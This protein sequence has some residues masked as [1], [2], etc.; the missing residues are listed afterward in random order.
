[1]ARKRYLGKFEGC[2]DDRLGEALYNTYPDETC[3][4]VCE[5]G[6]W[7]GLI[8]RSRPGKPSY[9]VTE[10]SQGFVDYAAFA[11]ED[12]AE[13]AFAGLAAELAPED[14]EEE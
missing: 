14:G 3:G 5:V 13:K 6:L 10:D 1:M 11:T 2:A 7:A 12:E 8:R 9:I 4:D